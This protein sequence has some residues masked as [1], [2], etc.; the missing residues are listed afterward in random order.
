L[1]ALSRK[2]YAIPRE[3]VEKTFVINAIAITDHYDFV[4]LP[5]LETRC[6]A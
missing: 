3:E 6:R 1:V 4:F 2:K 5:I